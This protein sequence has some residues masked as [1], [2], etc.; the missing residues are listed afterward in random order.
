MS[1][2]KIFED[3]EPIAHNKYKYVLWSLYYFQLYVWEHIQL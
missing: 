2:K 1:I 3:N